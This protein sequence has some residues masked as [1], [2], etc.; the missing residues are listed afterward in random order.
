MTFNATYVR[1]IG[2]L[3]K[4]L[5][6]ATPAVLEVAYSII[7][8]IGEQRYSVNERSLESVLLNHL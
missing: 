1:A 4:L 2:D 5:V 3:L 6:W 7:E 8:A